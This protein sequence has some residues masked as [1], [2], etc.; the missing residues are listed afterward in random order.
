M[1][2]G[3]AGTGES[4]VSIPAHHGGG[5]GLDLIPSQIPSYIQVSDTDSENGNALWYLSK[6]RYVEIHMCATSRRLKITFQTQT[7]F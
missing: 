5:G 6:Y 2:T 4:H 1:Q 3:F 7:S